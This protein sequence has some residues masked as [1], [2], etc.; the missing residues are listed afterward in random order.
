MRRR[1]FT[2]AG[3]ALLLV[4]CAVALAPWRA[5]GKEAGLAEPDRQFL[6][7][8]SESDKA[9]AAMNRLALDKT[10]N[11]SIKQF[12]RR[13]LDE[14][15]RRDAKLAALSQA[16]R[17]SPPHEVDKESRDLH[18]NIAAT[19]GDSFDHLFMRN[20]V[21]ESQKTIDLY[22]QE[23][24]SG[25]SP[26][27]KAFVAEQLPR[28]QRCYEQARQA[29]MGLPGTAPLMSPSGAVQTHK[30]APPPMPR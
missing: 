17:L 25:Q 28:L 19:T 6:Y 7:W 30:P 15:R 21:D 4:L 1:T 3:P 26:E 29:E 12:A 23:A 20:A 9:D 8:A 27:I 18:D 2:R 22:E 14:D 5:S 11:P 16:H 24:G 10:R 13:A